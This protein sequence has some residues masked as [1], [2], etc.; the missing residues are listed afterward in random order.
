MILADKIIELRKKAGWSQEELAEKLGVSRQS[1]S[2]WEG[3]QSVPDMNRILQ[4]SELFQVSTD[5][6]LKDGLEADEPREDRGEVPQERFVSM[7][8]ANAFLAYKAQTTPRIALGVGLCIL[9]PVALILLGAAQAAGRLRLSEGQAL[10]LGLMILIALVGT[11]VWL[12]VSS[13]L[14]GSRFEYLVK[15]KL[16]TAYGVSGMVKERMAQEAPAHARGIALGVVLCVVAV[17]PLFGALFLFGENEFMGA[18]GIGLL[19]LLVA[20][21]VYIIL[22]TAIPWDGYQVLLEQG[23]YAPRRKQADK[24][25]GGAYWAVLTAGYLLISFLTARWDITWVIWPVGALV[26]GAVREILSHR[27]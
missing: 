19:L 26:F 14:Q 1:V 22:R 15:E 25:Y 7:E 5:Y 10:M 8:E 12:F 18:G 2:K 21:G 6:L 4:L 17:I 16:D 23:D 9:S 3:A 11:A 13:G 20:L 27:G 24:N